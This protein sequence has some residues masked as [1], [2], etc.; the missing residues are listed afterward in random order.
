[1]RTFL[2]A[3]AD[4]QE[5]FASSVSSSRMDIVDSDSIKSYPI[6][7]RTVPASALRRTVDSVNKGHKASCACFHHVV[8]QRDAPR[9]ELT[10]EANRAT[11]AGTTCAFIRVVGDRWSMAL[12]WTGHFTR[13]EALTGLRKWR[14]QAGSSK[15]V[16]PA[17]IQESCKMVMLC[18]PLP[19]KAALP[20]LRCT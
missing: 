9:R 7:A 4:V 3:Q 8:L 11:K 19:V 6:H 14:H 1:M 17:F 10:S 5:G 12:D 20:S 16:N 13:K 15:E 2:N 18:A